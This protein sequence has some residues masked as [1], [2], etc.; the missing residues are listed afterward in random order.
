[1]DMWQRLA[2]D[3]HDGA[4]SEL[5]SLVIRLKQVEEGPNTPIAL[6]ETLSALGDHAIAALESVRAIAHGI[7]P[8]PLTK[9]GILDAL[10]AHAARVPTH[11]CISGTAPR[12]NS[13]A[14]AAVHFA[15]T[16]ALQNVVKHARD[17]A[18][19][20]VS[21]NYDRATLIVRVEDDGQG[22]SRRR[23]AKVPAS[24]TSATASKRS[25]AATSSPLV[26]DAA[27]R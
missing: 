13:D 22:L 10:R 19:V 14:E 3:L 25:V 18:R 23:S 7:D 21:L 4:Q 1:M 27:P 6:A 15:C 9:L 24:E 11:V 8:L 20:N 5:V 12:S 2:R 17:A 16:E 26:Q